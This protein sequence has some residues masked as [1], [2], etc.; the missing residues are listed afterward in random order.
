MLPGT[1][2]TLT[3]TS[4]RP[5]ARGRV[6]VTPLGRGAPVEVELTPV[7]GQTNMAAGALEVDQPAALEISVTDIAGLDAQQPHRG[8]VEMLEDRPP[9]MTVLEPGRQAVA[10]PGQVIPLRVRAEDD[11]GVTQV[12]WFRS[13]NQSVARPHNML[14][15][16]PPEAAEAAEMKEASATQ[17][18]GAGGRVDLDDRFDLASLGA[19]VGDR[20]DYF[21]ESRDNQPGQANFSTTRVFSVTIISEADFEKLVRQRVAQGT[22]L[23]QYS[24]LAK[25]LR[26]AEQL[27][28]ELR[29]ATQDAFDRDDDSPATQKKLAEQADAFAGAMTKYQMALKQMLSTPA[30]F[31]IESALREQLR[32]QQKMLENMQRTLDVSRDRNRQNGGPGAPDLSAMLEIANTLSRLSRETQQNIAQPAQRIAE[33]T[34]LMALAARFAQL[35]QQQQELLKLADRFKDRNEQFT[36]VEQLQLQEIA[37]RQQRIADELAKLRKDIATQ[38]AKLPEDPQLE[39]FK[40]QIDLFLTAIEQFNIAADLRAAQ[41]QFATL[42]GADGYAAASRALENMKKLVSDSIIQAGRQGLQQCLR[43]QPQLQQQTLAS[44]EDLLAALNGGIQSG[45][46][47][48]GMYGEQYALYGPDVQLAG[49]PASA[50]GTGDNDDASATGETQHVNVQSPGREPSLSGE[51]PKL[52]P[53]QL[54]GPAAGGGNYPLQYRQAVADYFQAVAQTEEPQP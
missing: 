48:Y 25:H 16:T 21:F 13:V 30:Y 3:V 33:V 10:T 28:E 1:R 54:P 4:N 22:L 41:D 29:K 20:I 38:R 32:P 7:K 51:F 34:R 23:E 37:A 24:M 11:F 53:G 43:F 46:S 35:T 17:L 47:G 12:Q 15:P 49:A 19:K 6:R 14:A 31:E 8:R 5:L 52:L 27:G 45:G 2:L 42:R 39:D 26:Y 44:L 50:S 40:T 36:R 18:P 9:R